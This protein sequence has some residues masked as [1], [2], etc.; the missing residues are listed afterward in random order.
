MSCPCGASTAHV[1]VRVPGC[2]LFEAEQNEKRE[3]AQLRAVAEWLNTGRNPTGL[4]VEDVQGAPQRI[5]RAF[6]RLLAAEESR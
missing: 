1:Y 5:A 6:L 2:P 4:T 3:R